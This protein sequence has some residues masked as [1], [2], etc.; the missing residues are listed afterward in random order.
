MVSAAWLTSAVA[1]ADA[2][3]QALGL[4]EDVQHEPFVA[5]TD[6]FGS[7]DR[8]SP[9]NRPAIVTREQGVRRKPGGKEI[10]YRVTVAFS[11]PIVIDPRDRITLWDGITGPI[12][13]IDRG[14]VDPSTGVPCAT[15]VFLGFGG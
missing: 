13:D 10:P 15:T 5:N 11:R 4:Q 6:G 8:G 9:A 3:A 12:V 2:A 7:A 1:T 14:A